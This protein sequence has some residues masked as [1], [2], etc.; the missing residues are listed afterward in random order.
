MEG[1]LN[2]FKR[3]KTIRD[4]PIKIFPRVNKREMPERIREKSLSNCLNNK[5]MPLKRKR[6]YERDNRH[7]IPNS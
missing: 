6:D 5:R 3:P 7:A 2:A 1:I 4:L